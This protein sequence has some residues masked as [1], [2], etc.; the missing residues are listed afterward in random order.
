MNIY[1]KNLVNKP[2]EFEKFSAIN[3]QNDKFKARIGRL[4]GG[5]SL[6]LAV[7]FTKQ[8]DGM[9]RMAPEAKDVE[10]L[11]ETQAK[12]QTALAQLQ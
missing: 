7:G 10:L 4:V 1:V 9:L 6:L 12:I 8:D 11:K 3:S 5:V 2:A